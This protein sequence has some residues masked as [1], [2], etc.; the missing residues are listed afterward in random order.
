[1]RA[2][3]AARTIKEFDIAVEAACL[4]LDDWQAAFDA[5]PTPDKDVAVV[6]RGC[7]SDAHP[8]APPT[9]SSDRGLFSGLAGTGR[10][11]SE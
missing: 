11:A 5:V 10:R 7:G 4:I 6:L 9:R 3:R 1:M 8:E 2:L